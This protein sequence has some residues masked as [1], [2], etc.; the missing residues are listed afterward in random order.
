MLGDKL[1]ILSNWCQPPNSTQNHFR[2]RRGKNKHDKHRKRGREQG[3]ICGFYAKHTM[4]GIGKTA[5]TESDDVKPILGTHNKRKAKTYDH[6]TRINGGHGR[7]LLYLSFLY[8]GSNLDRLQVWGVG[9]G[10][11]RCDLRTCKSTQRSEAE[12]LIS[13]TPDPGTQMT[14]CKVC[15]NTRACLWGPG[16]CTRYSQREVFQDQAFLGS[17]G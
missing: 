17:L 9:T 13:M 14:W 10:L 11:K 6:S 3:W 7:Y 15:N 4:L 1:F 2:H 5:E 12:E 16:G 8:A